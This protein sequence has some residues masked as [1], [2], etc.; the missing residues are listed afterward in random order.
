MTPSLN[1]LLVPWFPL[2]K[3]WT[4]GSRSSA[5]PAPQA[6]R[7]LPTSH[8]ILPSQGPPHRTWGYFTTPHPTDTSHCPTLASTWP[9]HGP[10]CLSS[11][12]PPASGPLDSFC[13]AL[14]R[15]LCTEN[16]AHS[17]SLVP[18]TLHTAP[19][20]PDSPHVTS[21]HALFSPSV[22]CASLISISRPSTDG[23]LLNSLVSLR[24]GTSSSLRS[25][26][27]RHADRKPS[28][29]TGCAPKK[30]LL[31]FLTEP[32]YPSLRFKLAS[33]AV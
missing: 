13:G 2:E 11:F 3:P 6:L 12:N 1:L 8:L 31:L 9:Y 7:S 29:L 19:S 28:L 23:S 14:A 27:Q 10:V 15:S 21:L 18:R 5:S 17:L 26:M 24:P 22:V 16:K 32:K 33:R 20:S 25:Q 30:P 4:Q